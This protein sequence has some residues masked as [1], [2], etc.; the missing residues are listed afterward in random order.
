MSEPS[1]KKSSTDNTEIQKILR[2][3]PYENGFHFFTDLGKY[4][5]ETAISL[6]SFLEELKTIDLSSVRFH[7]QRHEFQKWIQQTLGDNELTN[8]LDKIDVNLPDRNLKEEIIKIVQARFVQLQT[9]SN[10]QSEQK[11]GGTLEELKKFKFEELKQY[12][13]KEGKPVYIVFD[14]KV[15]DASSSGSWSG[16][17]HKAIHQAGKDLTQDIIS[18]PHGEEVFAKVKQVGVLV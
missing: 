3:V 4:S 15:F 17:V 1:E 14:G 16:G 10:M 7:F 5:G 2:S 18:A 13:G 8:H 11:T 6:F 9:L 12:D